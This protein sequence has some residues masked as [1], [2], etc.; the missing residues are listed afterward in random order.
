MFLPNLKNT[1]SILKNV[2][3]LWGICIIINIITF[4]YIYIKIAPGT[5]TLALHYNV[6]VGVE[7][8]GK[9][10]DLY[11]I[12]AAALIIT[13]VNFTLYKFIKINKDLLI[14]STVLASLVVQFILML[15]AILLKQVN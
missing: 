8:F 4:L 10:R 1:F 2:S 9:G 6:L 7:L 14:F 11:L 12:P 3:V 13:A 5:Q 15:S